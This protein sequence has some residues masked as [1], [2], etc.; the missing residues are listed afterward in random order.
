MRFD[1]CECQS[2]FENV[3]DGRGGICGKCRQCIVFSVKY[4]VQ[5]IVYS[6]YGV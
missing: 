1:I 4:T 5:C 2:G 3:M 6:V